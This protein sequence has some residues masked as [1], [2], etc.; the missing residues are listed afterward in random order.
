[1]NVFWTDTA[2]EH[3]DA[4]YA[5]VA[6][7]SEEYAKRLVDRLTSRSLQIA[8]FPL[9]GRV[10]P[11]MGVEQIREVVEGPFR[12]VY[13]IKPDRVDVLAVLHG[14]QDSLRE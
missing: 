14:A 13:H 3:L 9:S 8:Q 2:V 1:L 11:E 6:R 10:V 5:Y 7:T 12:I 4:L